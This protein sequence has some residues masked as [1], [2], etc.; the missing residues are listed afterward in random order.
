[1]GSSLNIILFENFCQD[2]HIVHIVLI[3]FSAKC[4]GSSVLLQ[5]RDEGHLAFRAISL[6][7]S[8]L[9]V[10]KEQKHEADFGRS[11]NELGT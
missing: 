10:L 7:G 8:I 3:Y 5:A 6:F 4:E 11:P 1:M 9:F 2:H